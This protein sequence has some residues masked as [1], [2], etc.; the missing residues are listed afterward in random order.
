[1]RT[2]TLPFDAAPFQALLVGMRSLDPTLH[3]H[4]LRVGSL[5]RLIGRAF[6]LPEWECERLEWAG[7]L[8]DIGKLFV[9]PF[10]L[11][12]RM[13]LDGNE[14][15]IMQRHA[16]LGA[17]LLEARRETSPLAPAARC[18]HE[19]WN[20]SGY[21]AHLRGREIPLMARIISV[22]DVYDAVTSN[23]P[24]GGRS[25]GVAVEELRSGQGTQFCPEVV[26]AFLL[27]DRR[28]PSRLAS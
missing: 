3:A 4:G 26:E 25:H 11:H 18:H 7:R 5:A 21:P 1:M 20:G 15:R 14:Y 8:H 22:A 17:R 2:P 16:G 24:G 13:P 19:R 6:G 10:L 27:A 9:P 28:A 12:K 23:R